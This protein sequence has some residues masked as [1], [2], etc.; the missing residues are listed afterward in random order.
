MRGPYFS[1]K[2]PPNRNSGYGPELGSFTELFCTNEHVYTFEYALCV[3][4]INNLMRMP[5]S[6]NLWL[7]TLFPE[8]LRISCNTGTHAL[9]VMYVHT[10][11]CVLQTLRLV[12]TYIS[13][14]ELLPMLQLLNVH[15]YI[16]Q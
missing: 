15:S 4:S 11:P 7:T 5:M 3:C 14:N 6:N 9:P 16:A 10:H 2:E 13:D 12:H 8:V 1:S